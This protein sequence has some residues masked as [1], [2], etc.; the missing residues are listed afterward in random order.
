MTTGRPREFDEETVLDAATAEFHERGY[1]ATALSGLLEATGLHKS[2]LYGAFGDKH[3]LFVTVLERYVERRVELGRADLE[4]VA[5]PL[6]G[7]KVYMRRQAREAH[8][9]R[10]C[11]SANSAMELLPGDLDVER[12][13]A[14][15][16]RLTRDLF[17]GALESAKLAGEIPADRPTET[18]ARYLFTMIEG[19]WE[20]GRTSA[21]VEPLYDVVD[22]TIRAVR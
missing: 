17:A 2:S 13:V 21:E 10:G 8:K 14:R 20:L 3:R 6:E 4:S 22:A 12:V 16:Q 15:H 19:L 18:L 5:S 7:I 11:L 1:H 9:G